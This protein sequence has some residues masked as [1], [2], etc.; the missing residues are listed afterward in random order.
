LFSIIS[1]CEALFIVQL[2]KISDLEWGLIWILVQ[3]SFLE[4]L[5]I[6]EN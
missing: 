4:W 2:W 3:L 6:C 5:L 1:D